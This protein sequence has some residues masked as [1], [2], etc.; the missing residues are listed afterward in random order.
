MALEIEALAQVCGFGETYPAW[1]REKGGQLEDI[2]RTLFKKLGQLGRFEGDLANTPYTWASLLKITL[3]I[4]K[5]AA[6]ENIQ[7]LA[8]HFN[9]PIP[10]DED[11]SAMDTGAAPVEDT[12]SP[13]TLE[14][15]GNE[16]QKELNQ[17]SLLVYKVPGEQRQT[18][19]RL[20]NIFAPHAEKIMRRMGEDESQIS[21]LSKQQRS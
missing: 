17:S 9:V 4:P 3:S 8:K 7:K 12:Q 2:A 19:I 20:L 16:S 13:Y 5:L 6:N 1:H 15:N 10:H 21:A 11:C 18:I 14:G